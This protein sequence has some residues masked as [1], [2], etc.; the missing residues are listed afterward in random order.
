MSKSKTISL[1]IPTHRRGERVKKTVE[2]VLSSTVKPDEIIIAEDTSHEA[3]HS[4][5]DYIKAGSLRYFKNTNSN[6]GASSTRN[7]GVTQA[8]MNFVLFLDDDDTLDPVYIA[9]LKKILDNETVVWGF[10]DILT[11]TGRSKP[12]AKTA[13]HLRDVTF[14]KKL[15]GMGAGFFIDRLE[16]LKLGSLKTSQIVDEDTDICCRLV[17]AGYDPYY[18]KKIA[19]SVAR[20]DH[21]NRLTNSTPSDVVLDCYLQTLK[22][23]YSAF[24]HDQ[25][26]RDFLIDRVHRIL[27]KNKKFGMISQLRQYERSHTIKFLEGMR[28]LKYRFFKR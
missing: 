19:V 10:G 23:N 5:K 21:E 7:F 17:A 4:L 28:E 9:E 11:D 8:S 2:S 16:F 26:A 20:N 27:C 3:E 1:V 22:A 14:R 18:T 13:G 6:K 25:S 24:A 15:C 12:R